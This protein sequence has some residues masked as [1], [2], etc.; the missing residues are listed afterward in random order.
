M[1]TGCDAGLSPA[2]HL[3]RAK[4]YHTEGD[5]NASIIELKNVLQSDSGHAEAHWLLGELYLEQGNGAATLKELE[6]AKEL[7]RNTPELKIALLR[8]LLLQGKYLEVILKTPSVNDKSAT[9]ELLTL[10]GEAHMKA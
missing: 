4:A 10:R 3:Q 7:G 8:S 6:K 5:L 1:L 2:E 9:T